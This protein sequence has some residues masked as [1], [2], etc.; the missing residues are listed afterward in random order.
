MPS[1]ILF[2]WS[3]IFFG[4]FG[5]SVRKPITAPAVSS[6][7]GVGSK[8]S[9]SSFRSFGPP[10]LARRPSD[11]LP[12]SFWPRVLAFGT[13]KRSQ[14]DA[15]PKANHGDGG[16]ANVRLRMAAAADAKRMWA[17]EKSSLPL[18]LPG[19]RTS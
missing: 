10:S 19:A 11:H 4:L 15:M 6:E 17:S 12:H 8:G 16:S 18:S 3:S 14:Y 1:R 13:Q 5:A 7:R 2:H 9:K